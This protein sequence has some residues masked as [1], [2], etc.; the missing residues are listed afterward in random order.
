MPDT[1][2]IPNTETMPDTKT[3]P[4]KTKKIL[5]IHRKAPIGTAYAR[6]ALDISLAASAFDQEVSLLFMDDGVF[7]LKS[8]QDSSQVNLKG[9]S[10]TLPALEMYDIKNVFVDEYSLSERGLQTA[11]LIINPKPLSPTEVQDLLQ[12]NDILLSF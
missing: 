9:I 11:D 8:G 4:N 7:Q 10:A 1:E 5:I 12:Q 2:T 6:D 3:S